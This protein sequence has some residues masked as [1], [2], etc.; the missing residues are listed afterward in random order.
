MGRKPNQLI[1]EFFERGQKLEDASNRYQHTCKA[2]GEKFP[3]GRIDSLT[4][5]LVKKCPAI[6]LRDRQRALLQLHELPTDVEGLEP[7]PLRDESRKSD[8]EALSKASFS[9]RG[10]TVEL[11]F[12][13]RNLT[14]LE[15][16]AEVSRQFDLSDQVAPVP[17]DND[18]EIRPPAGFLL[19]E[20]WT[21]A[22][23][24]LGYEE[25]PH[26]DKRNTE[27]NTPA[28][29]NGAPLPPIQFFDSMSDSP[30]QSPH[31][32]NLSLPPNLITNG[33]SASLASLSANDLRAVLPKPGLP[34][35][36][37]PL[38]SG[39]G[40]ISDNFFHPRM[41]RSSSTW[42]LMQSA[43][44]PD[45][46]LFDSAH[47]HAVVVKGVPR[48][49]TFPRA[50]AIN[51]NSPQREF[52]A[53]FSSGSEKPARPKVRGRFTAS[54][55]KEVQEVRK[56]GA[57]IRCRMLKKPCSG[58]SPCS[59]CRNVESARLWKQPCIRTRIADELELYSAGLHAVLA[60][61]EINRAKS[62]VH[63]RS[64]GG[65]IEA[66]HYSDSNVSVTFLALEG[67]KPLDDPGFN[68]DKPDNVKQELVVLDSESEDLPAKLEQYLKKMS[69][70]FYERE[71]SSF[72]KPTLRI[73]AELS[74]QKKDVLLSRVLELWSVNHV[75][76]DH[77]MHWKTYEKQELKDGGNNRIPIDD[78][79][80]RESYRLLC[81]QLRS[82][83]EK[84][85][86]QIS[87]NVMNELERRLLQRTQ[88]GWFETFLV[89]IL[90]LNCVERS[91][92]LFQT[93]NSDE[94]ESKWPLDRRPPY[95]Y[96]QGEHFADMLQM[97]L[98]MRGLPPKTHARPEDGILASDSDETARE[99]FD[100][101]RLSGKTL[102]ERQ[103]AEFDPGD[104]RSLELKF[105]SK[106]LL[107]S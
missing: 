86:A 16:L 79:T 87:K 66:T 18:Q 25:R 65:Q 17:Q 67:R 39:F 75:L 7:A 92:W 52:R 69:Q 30:S 42:P 36:P 43:P 15:T 14:P 22:N 58:E 11:P 96:E 37:E 99:Y 74:N 83:A 82:A 53:E 10:A 46:T 97:L 105:C 61:L 71:L 77:E 73:A 40:S 24:P 26:Q 29:C 51:P 94:Y 8:A 103:F 107:P 13:T 54:R 20:Q 68:H 80:D 56:R 106:L 62:R 78:D 33:R 63:F 95:Y 38:S 41:P 57:C 59:T 44:S 2:C 19:E 34:L 47:D 81:T 49:A 12:S 90:L 27:E 50:I 35:E 98:K 89:A 1:L 4:T 84:R 64:S 104:S 5:H 102:E 60:F 55:R 31:L 28:S 23:P 72:M 45:A 100:R 93:W 91:S 32:P 9:Q 21:Q 48:A 85:A 76:V 70:T 101:I 3:K 6:A 88:S